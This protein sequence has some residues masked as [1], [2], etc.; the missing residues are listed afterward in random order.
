MTVGGPS[1]IH[2]VVLRDRFSSD[3]AESNVP[4]GGVEEVLANHPSFRFTLAPTAYGQAVAAA[5]E[6]RP[7]LLVLDGVL[8]DPAA[9]V[10]ELDEVHPTVP[11]VVVLEESEGDLINECVIAGARACLVRPLAYDA[12]AQTLLRVHETGVRRR[13]QAGGD[14]KKGR[15]ITVRGAKGGSGVTVIAANLAVAIRRLSE[16]SVVLVDANFFGADAGVA[17]NLAPEQSV[18]DLA[19]RVQALDD[20]VIEGTLA[21]HP[22][23]VAL[24]AAPPELERAEAVAPEELQQILEALRERFEYVVV[25]SSPFLD[26]N[27]LVTLDMADVLLLVCTPELAGLKNAARFLVLSKALG[28]GETKTRLV[29]N[30]IGEPVGISEADIR[31]HLRYP[32]SFTIP[33][34]SAAVGGSFTRGEPLVVAERRSKTARALERLARTVVTDEGWQDSPK[35]ARTSRF[36]FRLPS[37]RASAAS[38]VARRHD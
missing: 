20:D 2:V 35:P 1:K 15:I 19:A 28:Y 12:L 5:A 3:A 13:K 22:T 27:T 7:D 18:A 23:G 16:R 38:V 24:L 32:I 6:Q 29:V 10:A 25:D 36:T 8:G 17:L 4:T 37:L 30:T 26:Q 31:R 34:D 9:L 21:R 11:Q 14:E 33:R